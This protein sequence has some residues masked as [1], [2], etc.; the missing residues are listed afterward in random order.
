M[1]C[2]SIK[3]GL[4]KA[5]T[6]MTSTSI[7]QEWEVNDFLVHIGH[8]TGLVIGKYSHHVLVINLMIS[9]K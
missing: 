1:V 3:N 2:S 9:S 7:F 4:A 5:K 8:S 6:W